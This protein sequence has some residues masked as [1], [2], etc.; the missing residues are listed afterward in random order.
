MEAFERG[1]LNSIDEDLRR[2]AIME[3]S[4][5]K[6]ASCLPRL[7]ALLEAD[8]YPNRRHIVRALGNIGGEANERRLLELLKIEDG[9]ILGDIAN[10]LGKV[11][12]RAA[13][14]QLRELEAHPTEW[15]TQN[16]RAA[17][18]KIVGSDP[19]ASRAE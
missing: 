15:V 9:L 14:P 12:S 3:A 18:R 2:F 10:A 1:D 6:D 4:R 7:L 19:G 8:T 16:A 13:L 11:G 5:T 17:I